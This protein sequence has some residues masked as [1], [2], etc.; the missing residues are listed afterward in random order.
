MTQIDY[1]GH[2]LLDV[3]L[4]TLTAFARKRHPRELTESDLRKAAEYMEKHYIAKPLR[5]FLT[6]V[7]PNSGYTQPAFEKQPEKQKIY[8]QRVLFSFDS[9]P[10]PETDPFLGCPAAAVPYDAYDVKSKL[11]LGRA[12]RQHVPL[13]TGEGVINFHA[14]GDAGIPLSGLSMLAFQALPLGCAKVGARLLA[15]YSDDPHLL[16]HF[17]RTFLETNK[18]NVQIAQTADNDELP[19]TSPRRPRTLL[20][21]HLL[22]AEKARLE[23]GQEAS[24]ATVTAYYFSNY[25][26]A[27]EIRIFPLPL[28]VSAFLG[29]VQ[30]PKYIHLWEKLVKRG[31]QITQQ[32]G[33]ARYNRLYEDLFTLPDAAPSFIRCYFL[34]RP[35]RAWDRSDPTPGYD[36]RREGD[37]ISWPLTE[38][39]L[40]KVVRMDERRIQYI[41]QLGESLATY[42]VER[43]DR[44][45]FNTFWMARNYGEVRAALIRAS[46]AE[47]RHGRPPLVNLDQ[48]LAI[49]EQAE[50]I[51]SADWHLGR[52]LVL[53]HLLDQLYQRGWLQAHA[54]ELPETEEV[55]EET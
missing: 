35:G 54:A 21:E 1:T 4:A 13:L 51:P 39:F 12:F 6:V 50:G 8:A 42:V 44:G 30:S 28:E 18:Q 29:S 47:V 48:F 23:K 7:F 32:G 38:L 3:G 15:V 20:I 17:A 16:L 33:E 10:S 5:S 34:R 26:K 9:F 46:Q 2:P 11:P 14:Y 31:W 25:G 45:F 55:T 27:A 40:R 37:L 24:P 52:D 53:I 22:A 49:F 36:T 19:D 41:Q 43:N